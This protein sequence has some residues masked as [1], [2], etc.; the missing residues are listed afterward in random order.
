MKR[1]ACLKDGSGI[2]FDDGIW[3]SLADEI[4]LTP[5][6]A[7]ATVDVLKQKV[8]TSWAARMRS[9]IVLKAV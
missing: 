8:T 6:A 9:Q 1:C 4:G 5:E 3:A 7:K 2:E